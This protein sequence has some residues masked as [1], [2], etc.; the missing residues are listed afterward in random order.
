VWEAI[1]NPRYC[2]KLGFQI[3]SAMNNGS[4]APRHCSWHLYLETT[5]KT[6]T[7][8]WNI[9]YRTYSVNEKKFKHTLQS[10]HYNMHI[11]YTFNQVGVIIVTHLS[12]SCW[13]PSYCINPLIKWQY[14]PRCILLYYFL[15][16]DFTCH[17]SVATQWVDQ[18]I[19][20]PIAQCSHSIS[21]KLN[22]MVRSMVRDLYLN[23]CQKYEYTLRY[24]KYEQP[25]V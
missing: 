15:L 17:G 1:S 13:N 14:A 6:L 24:K 19:C 9:T 16:N 25:L 22:T 18:T 12:V 8:I 4:A 21:L 20:M 10:I 7:R 23:C 11:I 3:P 5:S 2:F